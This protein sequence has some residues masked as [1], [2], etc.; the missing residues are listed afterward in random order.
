MEIA[1]MASEEISE[2]NDA[3]E[4]I[5]SLMKQSLKRDDDWKEFYKEEMDSIGPNVVV[6]SILKTLVL[7][8]KAAVQNYVG[9]HEKACELVQKIIDNHCTNESEKGWYLQ[10][11]ARYMYSQSKTESNNL[12]KS[13]FLQN[14]ELLKPKE[15]ITYKKL[16]FIN[17]TRIKRIQEWVKQHDGFEEIML[18]VESVLS[19]LQFGTSADK[20]EMAFKNLGTMLGFLSERPDKEYKKGPDNLW[21]G[22]SNQ[23]FIFECKSQVN[24]DRQEIHKSEAGQMNTHCGWFENQY[25]DAVVKR[26]LVIPTKNLSYQGDFT[27]DVEIMKRGT[28]R[29]LR[30]NVKAFFKEFKS[31]EIDS[32]SDDKIQGFINTHKIDISSLKTLYSEEYYCKKQLA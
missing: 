28:L 14:Q 12:Q 31:Y 30:N 3:I 17:E 19:D 15:G 1:K 2:K 29:L 7:E 32:L 23:Y 18:S 24:V 11:L 4:V 27:H 13:A 25:G 20:F 16:E 21:C 10:I 26:I 9:N 5:K 8:R 22:V 6:S